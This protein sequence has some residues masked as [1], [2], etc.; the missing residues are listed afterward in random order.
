MRRLAERAPSSQ[1]SECN[2]DASDLRLSGWIDSP[3]GVEGSAHQPMTIDSPLGPPTLKLDDRRLVSGF[4]ASLTAFNRQIPIR[5]LA[6]DEAF[7]TES[8]S[9]L[10]KAVVQ[11]P[12]TI[13]NVCRID[14]N[15][16][17]AVLP[18]HQPVE[19]SRPF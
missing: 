7:E 19:S 9:P 12:A 5:R 17:V 13:I 11:P 18:G 4:D 8:S 6:W 14:H 1:A 10:S 3:I 16:F 2:S 15:G